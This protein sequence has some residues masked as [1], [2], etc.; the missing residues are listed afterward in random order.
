[1]GSLHTGIR[2]RHGAY[3]NTPTLAMTWRSLGAKQYSAAKAAAS[4]Q[5]GDAMSFTFRG[6]SITWVTQRSVN[7]G[8]V[9]VY[10][11]GV[12][13]AVV[14]NYAARTA[15]GVKRVVSKLSDTVHTLNLVVLGTHHKG[16][17]G[18]WVTVD[19]FQVT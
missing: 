2:G 8:K 5:K 15:F 14:D 10:V 13:K 18:T 3:T 16:A 19:R 6:T 1:M 11:D 12:R 17:T 9:G 4:A 7:Q